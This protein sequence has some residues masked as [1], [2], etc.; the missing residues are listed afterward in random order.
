MGLF[1]NASDVRRLLHGCAAANII[2][3]MV[4]RWGEGSS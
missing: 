3:P 2:G 1:A 4:F